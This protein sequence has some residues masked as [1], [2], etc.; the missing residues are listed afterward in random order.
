[1]RRRFKSKRG[2]T[3]TELIIVLIIAAIITVAVIAV[4]VRTYNNLPMDMM[5]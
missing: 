4:L 1:M 3:L 2:F 5:G